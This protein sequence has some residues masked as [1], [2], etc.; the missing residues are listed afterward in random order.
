MPRRIP[1]GYA[2][3]GLTRRSADFLAAERGSA[4]R[5]SA[6]G[7]RSYL[8]SHCLCG[9]RDPMRALL[10]VVAQHLRIALHGRLQKTSRVSRWRI[11]AAALRL[12]YRA[13]GAGSIQLTRRVR[14]GAQSVLHQLSSWSCQSCPWSR[15]S[16]PCPCP[17]PRSLSRPLFH[18]RS[19]QRC[20]SSSRSCS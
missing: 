16:P 17:P 2:E 14:C 5:R 1:R 20:R 12:P 8:V 19:C 15:S 11:R 18:S 10:A 7:G 6:F 9:D 13:R 3:F 4:F